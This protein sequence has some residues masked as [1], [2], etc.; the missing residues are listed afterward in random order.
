MRR[1]PGPQ[2]TTA[3]TE[4]ASWTRLDEQ[5]TDLRIVD[6]DPRRTS[7]SRVHE[8][9][10]IVHFRLDRAPDRFWVRL[11]QE[12][13]SQRAH[14]LR[15]GLW[16][17]EDWLSFDCKLEDVEPTHLPDIQ[18]SIDYANRR[19]REV[20]EERRADRT[21]PGGES[22]SEAAQLDA[23]AARLRERFAQA[24]AE[25]PTVG[26]AFGPDALSQ[27]GVGAKGP[28][29]NHA[30]LPGVVPISRMD[31]PNEPLGDEHELAEWNRRLGLDTIVTTGSAMSVFGPQ[32]R[33]AEP[34]VDTTPGPSRTLLREVDL[35]GF[36]LEW[37]E[38]APAP[39]PIATPTIA[40]PDVTPA[41]PAL[42]E[43]RASPSEDPQLEFE[44]RRRALRE[45]LRAA[46]Q[47]G[48]T[49]EPKRGDD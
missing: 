42:S 21:G 19:Y 7:I 1:G 37:S 24:P 2:S 11:F 41:A 34:V 4:L 10:R 5:F 49:E 8:S 16:I 45:R 14:A 6:F 31:A 43:A 12:E 17:E 40:A 33:G 3:A 47:Q 48:A 23:L 46:A 44:R 26:G 22:A 15:F 35:G 39:P 27:R 32:A 18:A 9:M 36:E 29:H 28:S 30:P 20:L 13:R 25:T 38:P